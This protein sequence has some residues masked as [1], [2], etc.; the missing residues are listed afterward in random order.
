M[1]LAFLVILV[2]FI[3]FYAINLILQ[4]IELKRIQPIYTNTVFGKIRA[5]QINNASSSAGLSFR[6]DT[7]DG[8]PITATD[9]AKVF[10]LPPPVARFGYREKVYLIAK[11]LG[12]NTDIV[13]YQL[14]GDKA[15]LTD[16]TQDLTVDIRNFN[17]TYQFHFENTPELFT[18]AATPTTKESQD[19]AVNFLQKINRYPDE[20]TQGT[21]NIIFFNYNPEIKQFKQLDRNTGANLAEVDFYRPD[22]DGFPVVSPTFFNSQNYVMVMMI[23]NSEPRI[24]KAQI[25]FFEKSGQQVGYYPVKTGDQAFSALKEGQ[26]LVVSNPDGVNKVVIKTMGLGYFEPDFYQDYFQPVYVFTGDNNFVAYVPAITDDYLIS[27]KK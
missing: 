14:Q 17:F 22:V 15:V 2:I 12:F 26:G 9:S 11:T 24:I 25:N 1:P 18:N 8:K 27:D 7:V 23:P 6:L 10:Y 16:P 20:F 13:K 21:P 3:I 19:R 5:P 4:V